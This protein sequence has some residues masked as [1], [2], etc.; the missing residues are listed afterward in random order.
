[1]IKSTAAVL[2]L[3]FAF[4]APAS[5]SHCADYEFGSPQWWSCQSDKGGAGE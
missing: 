5:A 2:V 3:M 1:M 4:A